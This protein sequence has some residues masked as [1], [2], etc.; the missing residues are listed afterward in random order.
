M[1]FRVLR[2]VMLL[3]FVLS[4]AVQLNDPDPFRWALLYLLAACTC[5]VDHTA[6]PWL[7]RSQIVLRS[8]LLVTAVIGVALLSND[9][10]NSLDRLSAGSSVTMATLAEERGREAGGLLIVG[11]WCALLLV[12][13]HW[14]ST[15]K[16][17]ATLPTHSEK[18][19]AVG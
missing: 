8:T 1:G 11:V 9:L 18:E 12:R 17:N 2:A 15:T 19:N 14:P 10:I 13:S 4:A 7:H 6:T 16:K 5:I 3:L